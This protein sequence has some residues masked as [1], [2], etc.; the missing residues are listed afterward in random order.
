MKREKLQVV[1]SK[2]EKTLDSNVKAA[3]QKKN[4]GPTTY[5]LGCNTENSDL[6]GVKTGHTTLK[7]KVEKA[8]D[9]LVGKVV[10]QKRDNKERDFKDNKDKKPFGAKGKKVNVENESD[11]PKLA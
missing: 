9:E 2:T 6:L 3:T 1:H 11:F 4:K 5:S 7:F 8:G 10:E